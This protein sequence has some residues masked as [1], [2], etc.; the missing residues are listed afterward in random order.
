MHAPDR[1][2]LEVAVSSVWYTVQSDANGSYKCGLSERSGSCQQIRRTEGSAADAAS[3]AAS[4]APAEAAYNAC[5]RLTVA[6]WSCLC[7]SLT[8][9]KPCSGSKR[10]L[11]QK[12]AIRVRPAALQML[13]NTYVDGLDERLCQ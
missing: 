7:T 3:F 13:V 10:H 4:L 1:A 2:P 12:G 5:C 6:K 8:C 9:S 11:W